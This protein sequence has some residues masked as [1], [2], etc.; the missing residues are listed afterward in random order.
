MHDIVMNIIVNNILVQR[1]LTAN[2]Q[3]WDDRMIV[4]TPKD[5]IAVGESPAVRRVE[6]QQTSC[7]SEA[8]A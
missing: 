5:K 1:S 6:G 4:R 7:R 3:R 2:V 8:E